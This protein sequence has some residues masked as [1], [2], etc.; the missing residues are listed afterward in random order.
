MYV[1]VEALG[2]LLNRVRET[3]TSIF[4]TLHPLAVKLTS[5]KLHTPSELSKHEWMCVT[6]CVRLTVSMSGSLIWCYPQGG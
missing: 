2:Y 5:H 3:L 4:L 6:V 1:C